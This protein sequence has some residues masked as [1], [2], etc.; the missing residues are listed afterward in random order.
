MITGLTG[1]DYNCMAAI[2]PIDNFTS[3]WRKNQP[4]GIGV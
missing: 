2:S 4:Y 1:A 3:T